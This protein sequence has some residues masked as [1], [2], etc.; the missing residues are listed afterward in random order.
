MRF[1][2]VCDNFDDQPLFEV[3]GYKF[4]LNS[5]TEQVPATSP[6]LLQLAAEWISS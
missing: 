6:Q 1:A 4:I 3:D 5:L 2:P